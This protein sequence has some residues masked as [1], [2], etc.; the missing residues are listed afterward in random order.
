MFEKHANKIWFF[1]VNSLLLVIGVL[2][3]KNY[4]QNKQAKIDAAS[5]NLSQPTVSDAENAN[6]SSTEQLPIS[7]EIPVDQNQNA[8]N[9]STTS[10]ATNVT[11]STPT[12]AK[13]PTPTPTSASSKPSTKTKTS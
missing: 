13:T 6:L 5:A 7:N 2:L 4:E 10:S 12:K 9:N 8:S 11:V 1:V 3:I